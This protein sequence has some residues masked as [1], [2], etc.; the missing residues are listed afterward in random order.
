[1]THWHENG[2][3]RD[4]ARSRDEVGLGPA[5][6]RRWPLTLVLVVLGALGGAVAARSQPTTYTAEERLAVGSGGLSAQ[7]VP[8]FALASQELASNYARFVTAGPVRSALPAQTARRVLTVTASPVPESNVVRVEAT[9]TDPA[10]ATVA[11]AKAG[12]WLV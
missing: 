8:G 6:R 9:A 7:A 11:A 12:E 2:G 5:M 4:V 1:M 10:A 3:G